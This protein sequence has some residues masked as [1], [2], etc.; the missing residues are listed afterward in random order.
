[1]VAADPFVATFVVACE[2]SHGLLLLSKRFGR[3]R[4]QEVQRL[5]F[6]QR[7]CVLPM[8]K[9]FYL[10]ILVFLVG[11]AEVVVGVGHGRRIFCLSLPW[12]QIVGLTIMMSSLS[13]CVTI[14]AAE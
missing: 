7:C 14:R 3:S 13:K 4:M 6:A 10:A 12:R 1:M 8:V 9:Y 5:F 2:P 11:K